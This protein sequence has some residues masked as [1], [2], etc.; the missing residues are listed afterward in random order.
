MPKA[1]LNLRR[2]AV[3][4]Q[5]VEPVT[6]PT[7]PR[8]PEA[9]RRIFAKHAGEFDKYDKD[10]LKWR[11]EAQ[12]ILYQALQALKL[13]RSVI[14]QIITEIAASVVV[15]AGVIAETNFGQAPNEGASALASRE[16][17]TH[18]TPANPLP[19]HVAAPDPHPQYLTEAEAL[20]LITQNSGDDDA[21]DCAMVTSMTYGGM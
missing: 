15:G 6:L 2:Q 12:Y 1:P 8:F 3:S 9:L 14:E 4:K 5:A 20:D 16:D 7:P 13:D 11:D 19:G 21:C 10:M 18:G 17:H